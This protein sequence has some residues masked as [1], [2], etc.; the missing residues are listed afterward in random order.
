MEGGEEE[1]SRKAKGGRR[2]AGPVAGGGISQHMAG[3]PIPPARAPF[4]NAI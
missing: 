1:G 2:R 4:T 3:Q